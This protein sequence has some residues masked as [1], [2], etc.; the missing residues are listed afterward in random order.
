MGFSNWAKVKEAGSRNL[1]F[2]LRL[3]RIALWF[4]TSVC[5]QS[6]K[7]TAGHRKRG[8]LGHTSLTEKRQGFCIVFCLFI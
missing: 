6:G 4:F 3:A 1:S 5:K 7:S 8:N 2:L